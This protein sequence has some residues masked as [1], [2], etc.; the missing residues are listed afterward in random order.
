M[1]RRGVA[2]HGNKNHI[3][4]ICALPHRPFSQQPILEIRVDPVVFP[5]DTPLMNPFKTNAKEFMD[6]TNFNPLES[7]AHFQTW[8]SKCMTYLTE[9][10]CK[11]TRIKRCEA[12]MEHFYVDSRAFEYWCPDCMLPI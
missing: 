5:Q 8:C 7:F 10:P 12:C 2:Y 4:S 11:T 1:N 9:C 3:C 6:I